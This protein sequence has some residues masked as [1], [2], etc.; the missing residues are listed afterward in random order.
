MDFCRFQFFG[1][2]CQKNKKHFS[3]SILPR[4]KRIRRTYQVKCSYQIGGALTGPSHKIDDIQPLSQME[5]PERNERTFKM[6][7]KLAT[8]EEHSSYML[9]DSGKVAGFQV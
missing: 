7:L 3:M 6:V 5:Q 1:S 4:T 2:D 8:H 9:E